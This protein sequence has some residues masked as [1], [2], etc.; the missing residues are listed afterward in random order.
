M[1]NL[2]IKDIKYLP[3]LTIAI[4]AYNEEGL[5]T[6]I[7]ESVLLQY[8][9]VCSLK[10]VIVYCDGCFDNTVN[11]IK[12]FQKNSPLVCFY[13]G[14]ERIGKT[15]MLNRIFDEN[16]SDFLLVLDADIGLDGVDFIQRFVGEAIKNS[17]KVM[18]AAHQIPLEPKAFIGKF[19]YSSFLMWDYVR[20]SLPNK[21]HV[22]NFYG[23]ATIYRKS[24]TK[25][26]FIPNDVVGMR[27]YLYLLAKNNGGFHYVTNASI[28]YWPP[29]TIMDF[30]K[31]TKR[32]YGSDLNKLRSIFGESVKDVYLIKRSYKIKGII[33]FAKRH[34]FY[35][36]PAL[37]IAFLL[38]Y[39]TRRYQ[40]KHFMASGLWDKA[41][42]TKNLR[43]RY[44]KE[45]ILFFQIMTI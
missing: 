44:W 16:E 19:F 1:K 9:D 30:M 23:A 22:E 32:V 35:L 33:K 15:R 28:K 11:N 12:E 8:F 10:K 4:P 6:R 39:A 27:T 45:I 37:I 41:S 43:I 36:M 40:K 29:H 21:D 42:S 2:I 5:I 17:G 25:K 3:S 38:I 20:L 7:L 31:L 13:E 18:F 24:F 14:K 26:I 34:P